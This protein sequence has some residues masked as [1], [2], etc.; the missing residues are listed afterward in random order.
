MTSAERKDTDMSDA[1]A[2]IGHNRSPF[3]LRQEEI[4]DL[5]DEAKNWL[6]GGEVETQEDADGVS[7]LLDMLRKAVKKADDAR[8]EEVKP[9]DDGKAAVQERYA[10]LIADTKSK[11]GKAIIAIDACKKALAPFLAKQ[12]AEK[13]A[14]AEAAR[15]DAEAAEIAA[16]DAFTKAASNDLEARE[17]AERLAEAAKKATAL[18]S[19][20]EKDR[21]GAR[22]GARAVT[23]RTYYRAE[24]TDANE[25]ARY[26]WLN[27]RSEMDEFMS[28]I[29]R[30]LVNAKQRDIPGVTIHEDKRAA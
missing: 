5:Y 30:R 9:F 25:F 8:K 4:L 17:E 29:A 15:R 28:G 12:E 10:P 21:A 3:D 19:R 27:H 20:A 16:Q 11:K 6:D 7:K 18:A 26:L 2:T 1:T 14:A 23:L 22:G 13:R 24:V